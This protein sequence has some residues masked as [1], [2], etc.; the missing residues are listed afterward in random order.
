VKFHDAAS[1]VKAE[2]LWVSGSLDVAVDGGRVIAHAAEKLRRRGPKGCAVVEG[3]RF[4]RAYV[5]SG[6][7]TVEAEGAGGVRRFFAARLFVDAG[8]ADSP[9]ARQLNGGRAP[10]HVRTSVGTIARGFARGEGR[11]AA[12]FGVGEILVSTEDASAH[13]QLLWEGF[14]GSPARGE[15]TTRLFFYDSVDSPADKS[16]LSLFERYFESLPAYKQ[17]GAG[18]RVERPTFG[19]FPASRR[20]ERRGVARADFERVMI[21]GGA[22]G[23]L[24]SRHFGAR[25]RDLSR[26]AR[27]T[28]LALSTGRTD[29]DSLAQIC[30]VGPRA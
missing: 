5:E 12:D 25:V 27:L 26:A 20:S 28:H 22:A 21:L 23:V 9:V 17:K 24:A 6:R 15:Y 1:R 18:W 2:P 29:A 19:Y 16:L 10:S 14:A 8:G 11:D 13:R 4:V 3:L 7:V 30:D